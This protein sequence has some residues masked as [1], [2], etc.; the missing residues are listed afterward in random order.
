[1]NTDAIHASVFLRVY[2]LLFFAFTI[3]R[4]LVNRQPVNRQPVNRQP[5]NRQP[6]NRH[7]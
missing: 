6:M 1:M 7:R 5:V 2:I 4:Q 3:G